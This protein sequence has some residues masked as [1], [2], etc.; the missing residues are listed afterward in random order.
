MGLLFIQ[1]ISFVDIPVMSAYLMLVAFFFV[2]INLI[3][4]LLYYVV[5]PRLRVERTVGE[6]S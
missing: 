1:A 4:D 3:V 5:D 2:L 6:G